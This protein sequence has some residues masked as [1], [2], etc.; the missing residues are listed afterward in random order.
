[1]AEN[2]DH[3]AAIVRRNREAIASEW[4]RQ[5]QQDLSLRNN[6]LKPGE[7]EE[8][9]REFLGALT[10]ALANSSRD[11][12]SAPWEPVREYIGTMAR[13]RARQG[14]TPAETATF[15][16]SLKQSIF[17][18]LQRELAKDP[19][20]L[21]EETWTINELLDRLGLYSYEVYQK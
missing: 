14:F 4:A 19:Q 7:L 12:S 18:A 6:L 5:Q 3:L 20:R 11:I 2:D 17:R 21:S 1:M 13:A 8:Q 16:F 15:L 10:P 9:T